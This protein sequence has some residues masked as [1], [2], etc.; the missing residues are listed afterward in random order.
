[1]NPLMPEFDIYLSKDISKEG[2]ISKRY[3]K[4]TG[5]TRCVYELAED[6]MVSTT[7]QLP[8]SS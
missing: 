5:E 2:V 7:T 8:V 6:A 4:L 3:F 1:M